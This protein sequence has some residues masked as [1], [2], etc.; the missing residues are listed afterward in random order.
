MRKGKFTTFMERLVAA[1]S[2]AREFYRFQ[3]C[4]APSNIPDYM[5]KSTDPREVACYHM[6]QVAI[7]KFMN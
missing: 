5:S 7:A 2:L 3:G 4:E 6:A 1:E